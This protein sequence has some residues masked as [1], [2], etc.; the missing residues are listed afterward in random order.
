MNPKELSK[1]K[2]EIRKFHDVLRP[3]INYFTKN[4]SQHHYNVMCVLVQNMGFDSI[5]CGDYK[6]EDE[7]DTF[8]TIHAL[9]K[10]MTKYYDSYIEKWILNEINM[11]IFDVQIDENRDYSTEEAI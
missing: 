1:T 7:L 4:N 9:L 3:I 6:Y 2:E 8:D 10:S 11:I 5:D